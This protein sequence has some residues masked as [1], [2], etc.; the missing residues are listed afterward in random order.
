MKVGLLIRIS[1]SSRT[2]DETGSTCSFDDGRPSFPNDIFVIFDRNLFF[3]CLDPLLSNVL[4]ALLPKLSSVLTA[5]LFSSTTLVLDLFI[6]SSA[7]ETFGLGSRLEKR[8][9]FGNELSGLEFCLV[10]MWLAY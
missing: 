1:R 8:R 9:A 5:S 3:F 6:K 10:K 2:R 7:N 4:L